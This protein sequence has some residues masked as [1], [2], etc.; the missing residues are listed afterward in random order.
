[1][2]YQEVL[3]WT[4]AKGWF[5]SGVFADH[6]DSVSVSADGSYIVG[7]NAVVAGAFRWSAKEG[8]IDLG[9]G[10]GRDVS[11]DGRYVVGYGGGNYTAWLWE[12]I[13]GQRELKSIL[14]NQYGLNLNGWQLLTADAISEDGGVVTGSADGPN[15][16]EGY[17]AVLFPRWTR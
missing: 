10:V 4:Q 16:M 5:G 12:S 13:H 3:I 7:S 11:A 8:R 2:R 9:P 14:V 15:G 1:Q 6:R 17:I